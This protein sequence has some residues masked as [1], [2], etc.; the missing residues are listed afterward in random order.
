[1]HD[2]FAGPRGHHPTGMMLPQRPVEHIRLVIGF[3]GHKKQHG[4]EIAEGDNSDGD[5]RSTM[6]TP[7]A[8]E[9]GT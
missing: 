8:I 6:G 4:G 1:M 2:G 3:W 9:R 7:L 5:R